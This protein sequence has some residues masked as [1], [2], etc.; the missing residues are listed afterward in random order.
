MTLNTVSY[1][2]NALLKFLWYKKHVRIQVRYRP[3][4]SLNDQQKITN[5]RFTRDNT[6]DSKQE[7]RKPRRRNVRYQKQRHSFSALIT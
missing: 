1:Q 6:T 4:T 5:T 7:V 3:N 2:A